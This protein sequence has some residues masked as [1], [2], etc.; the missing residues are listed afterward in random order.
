MRS[1]T[2]IVAIALAAFAFNTRPPIDAHR[3]RTGRFVFHELDHGREI[4][5]GRVTIRRLTG[6]ERYEFSAD[7]TGAA[8]QR[9][10]AVTTPAFVP[11]SAA[12]AFGPDTV[13]NQRRFSLTYA[14]GRVTGFVVRGARRSID[15]VV[16]SGI[17]DQRIDWAAV[18]ASD[19]APGRELRFSVYDPDLGVSPVI[20]TVGPV[21]RVE[22]PAGTFNAYRITYRIAKLTGTVEYQLLAT[23][24]VPRMMV[25]EI[26]PDSVI[27]DL[28]EVQP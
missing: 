6:P 28:S 3:L 9:W 23:R 20:A 17:V 25:R 7:I 14:A 8:D 12:I 19:L 1:S 16:P 22:V 24:A 2:P 11:L 13:A 15:T 10:T 27:S 5:Q 18:M 21:E 4:G 26:F